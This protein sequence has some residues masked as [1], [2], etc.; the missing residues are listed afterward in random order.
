[1]NNPK[2]SIKI[3]KTERSYMQAQHRTRMYDTYRWNW[4]VPTTNSTD[5]TNSAW[6]RMQPVTS[7][8]SHIPDEPDTQ[9]LWPI[10][11]AAQLSPGFSCS[12]L[13]TPAWPSGRP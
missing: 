2:T 1:M 9:T 5:C 13:S 12:S 6:C 4:K 8:C 10:V 7:C 3:P 11:K